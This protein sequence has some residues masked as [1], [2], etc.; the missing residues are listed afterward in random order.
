LRRTVADVPAGLAGLTDRVLPYGFPTTEPGTF[1]DVLRYSVA[2]EAPPPQEVSTVSTSFDALS[3][4][5]RDG[6]FARS[7]TRRTCVLV[8]DGE[9]R[10]FSSNAVAR[11][12]DTRRGCSLVVI[13]VWAPGER[14]FNQDGEPERGYRSDPAAPSTVRRLRDATGGAEFDEHELGRAGVALHSL[15]ERGPTARTAGETNVRRLAPVLAAGALFLALG[16][17]I[18]SLAAGRRPFAG[19]QSDVG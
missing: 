6:F 7:A 5:P 4:L 12:L 10:P 14:I 18:S 3:A 8:T 17:G 13:Q 15:A 9:S 16:L 1:A 2:A 11:A 19:S